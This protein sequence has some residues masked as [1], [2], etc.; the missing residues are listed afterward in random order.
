MVAALVGE[1]EAGAPVADDGGNP[2]GYGS[3][4]TTAGTDALHPTRSLLTPPE[5]LAGVETSKS[6]TPWTVTLLT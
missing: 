5:F 2:E 1:L 6:A 3:L 4:L